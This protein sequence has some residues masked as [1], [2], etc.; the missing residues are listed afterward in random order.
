MKKTLL[1]DSVCFVLMTIKSM[2]QNSSKQ[3]DSLH[4]IKNIRMGLWPA[5]IIILV[6]LLTLSYLLTKAI[7][8]RT[9]KP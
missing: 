7:N 6:I 5:I 3:G 9:D 2:A 4:T 1:L 8:K